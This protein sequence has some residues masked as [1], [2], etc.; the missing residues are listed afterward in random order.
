MGR[1]FDQGGPPWP[2]VD[3]LGLLCRHLVVLHLRKRENIGPRVK[4][5]RTLES[6]MSLTL[7][8]QPAPKGADQVIIPMFRDMI[9]KEF[10]RDQ[11]ERFRPPLVKL[12]RK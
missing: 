1:T 2:L 5:D 10:H 4:V 6:E 9:D 3:Q 11:I 7:V 12:P 8:K